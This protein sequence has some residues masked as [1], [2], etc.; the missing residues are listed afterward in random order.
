MKFTCS[1]IIDK[2]IHEVVAAFTNDEIR[3][4]WQ[5]FFISSE[6]I[7][8]SPGQEGSRAR[9]VFK[10]PNGPQELTETIT[11][12]NL[13]HEFSGIY[14]HKHMDNTMRNLFTPISENSTR[15]DAE[16]EYTAFRGFLPKLMAWL[17]PGMFK[18]QVDKQL[19]ALKKLLESK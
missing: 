4:Q 3:N 16:V 12:N 14:E 7:N 2:P 1:I 18:K 13:P 11:V 6:P 15:Y 10:S 9:I 5:D 8:G 19:I 17:A